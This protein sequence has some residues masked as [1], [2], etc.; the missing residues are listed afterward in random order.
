MGERGLFLNQKEYLF[1]VNFWNNPET[2]GNQLWNISKK[3]FK[4]NKTKL[5]FSLILLCFFSK[6]Y[7][8]LGISYHQS[9]IPFIGV[10]YEIGEH[11]APELRLGTDVYL[12]NL[13]LEAIVTYK[14]LTKEDYD[15][16]GGLGA[17]I[18]DYAGIVVPIGFNFYPFNE[19]SFG[20][21]LEM[22]PIIGEGSVLRGSWGIRYR[23]GNL[24]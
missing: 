15:F 14:F 24:E 23:F 3:N 21:H 19:K 10:N 20:F 1:K 16:Y 11:F 6:S 7:S 17:R 8:Q 18:Q 9:S 22:T 2:P 12:E 13:S 5:L 4:M